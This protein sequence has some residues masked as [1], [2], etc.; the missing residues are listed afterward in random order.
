MN[1]YPIAECRR[2]ADRIIK[3]GGTIFQQFMCANCGEKN[4]VDKKN[5]FYA[6]GKCEDCGHVTNLVNEGC[7]Y[8]A[9]YSR[10]QERNRT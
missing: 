1:L 6:T 9:I 8:M 2:K 4:T 7:N 10:R 5:T 3:D